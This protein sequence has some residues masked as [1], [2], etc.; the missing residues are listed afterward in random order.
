MNLSSNIFWDTDPSKLDYEKHLYYIIPRVLDFGTIDD[1]RQVISFYG[2]DTII[3]VL[4]EVRYL[5]P[6]TISYFSWKY[7]LDKTRFRSYNHRQEWK[8]WD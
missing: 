4:L 1:V 8:L 5:S 3:R 6:K 2:D 7:G